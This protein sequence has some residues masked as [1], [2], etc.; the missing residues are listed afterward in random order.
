[1]GLNFSLKKSLIVGAS[2]LTLGPIVSITTASTHTYA[3][4]GNGNTIELN[5]NVEKSSTETSIAPV[6]ALNLSNRRLFEELENQGYSVNDIFTEE[7]IQQYLSEDMLRA[8]STQLVTTG[9]NTWTLYLSSAYTK[10]ISSLGSAA[11]TIIGALLGG[12]IG[13]TA[14][15]TF[16]GSLASQNIDGSRGIYIDFVNQSTVGAGPLVSPVG[17]GYQ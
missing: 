11:G 1:V 9:E 17:W 3:E 7:E 14:L 4:E 5:E 15:G 13:T 16:L 8:G 2:V 6:S 12:G 10:V